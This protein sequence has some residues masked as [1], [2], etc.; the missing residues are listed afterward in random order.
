MKILNYLQ[1]LIYSNK[2]RKKMDKLNLT[3]SDLFLKREVLVN[4]KIKQI[5][6]ID[7]DL[8]FLKVQLN[9]QFNH[10][11]SLVLQ[12][13]KSFEGAVNA[14]LKKQTRGI[15]YLEK[16]LLKAQK[17]K[18]SDHIQRLSILHNHLF[19]G[20]ILQERISNFT[21][22]YLEMG[23]NMIPS[24]IKCLDPLNPNFTLIEY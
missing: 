17:K 20:D 22:F 11:Q 23:E 24:L 18:L 15:D 1:A 14:Q 7:L 13:D 21:V 12:T 19:P 3:L 16:R 6:S 9:K 10:L 2:L 5:S 4:K 8:K